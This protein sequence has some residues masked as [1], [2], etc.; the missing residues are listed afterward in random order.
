MNQKQV[1]EIYDEAELITQ[2]KILLNNGYSVTV[3]KDED[4]FRDEFY[5]IIY[6]KPKAKEGAE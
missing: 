4:A 5:K 1:I 2:V 3:S 6:R